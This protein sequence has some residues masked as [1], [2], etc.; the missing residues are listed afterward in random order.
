MQICGNGESVK[1]ISEW[2]CFWHEK[3]SQTWSSFEDQ[4]TVNNIDYS[5]SPSNADSENT[6][7]ET[8]LKN[9]LLVTGPVGVLFYF[10]SFYIL[11]VWRV[12]WSLPGLRG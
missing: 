1:F 2:L 11:Y 3:G 8:A 7:G 5:W 4:N 12:F 6:D 10:S 9:V